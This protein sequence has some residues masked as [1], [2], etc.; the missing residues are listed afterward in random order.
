MKI[1]KT[2]TKI[3]NGLFYPE[4]Q[5]NKELDLSIII[6]VFNNANFTKLAL[7]GLTKLSNKYEIII[8]DN[9]STDET[10]KL[11]EEFCIDRPKE[12]VA[13]FHVLNDKN[14]GFGAANNVG[15]KYARSE[16]ILFLN[17]DIR[18]NGDFE[19]W[20][21]ETV[22]LC[23]KGFLV[24]TCGGLL[25]KDFEFVKEAIGLSQS[26]FWYVSGWFLGGSRDT[27]DR[28]ILTDSNNNKYCGPWN[29]EYFLYFEDVDLTWRAKELGIPIKEIKVPIY[30]FSRKTGKKYN[31]FGYYKISKRTLKKQ[32]KRS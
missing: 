29:E 3:D 32:W 21:E 14:L 24:G 19:T 6:P 26:K 20:P 30:H 2:N 13:V 9:A 31:M 25:N 5:K 22:D 15:Y 27:F 7:D 10:A 8:V 11:V 4:N 18:I 28:L 17:N 23:K 16:N 1:E 12:K